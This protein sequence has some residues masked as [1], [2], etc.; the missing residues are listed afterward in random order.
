MTPDL[1]K[2]DDDLDFSIEDLRIE[3][4]FHRSQVASWERSLDLSSMVIPDI[5][6]IFRLIDAIE[7]GDFRLEGIFNEDD[8][9]PFVK[10]VMRCVISG[11][12]Q[13]ASDLNGVLNP[14]SCISEPCQG[15][16]E[17]H[18]PGHPEVISAS[19]LEGPND[20]SRALLASLRAYTN[21]IALEQRS[22]A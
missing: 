17:V 15:Q 9:W 2:T 10:F 6:E 1:K 4:N 3:M 16:F 19:G 22:A 14:G 8:Y 21:R 11:S 20:G 5:P 18:L 13:S 7:I 12:V